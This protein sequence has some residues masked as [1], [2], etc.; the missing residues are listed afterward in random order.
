MKK[1]LLTIMLLTGISLSAGEFEN[2]KKACDNNDS[3]A[4]SALGT[5]Y[6]LGNGGIKQDYAKAIELYVKACDGGSAV[7]CANLGNMYQFAIQ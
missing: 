1:L 7:G 5:I 2:N 4:C 3:N 6:E